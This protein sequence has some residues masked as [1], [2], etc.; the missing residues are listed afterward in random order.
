MYS[1][2]RE[3]STVVQNLKHFLHIHGHSVTADLSAAYAAPSALLHAVS[4][5]VDK[6]IGRA[7]PA[8]L[9]T[10]A[11][12]PTGREMARILKEAVFAEFYLL[13]DD[14]KRTPEALAFA[15]CIDVLVSTGYVVIP[16]QVQPE[17]RNSIHS[18][19]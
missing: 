5:V 16:S 14:V 12:D 17:N 9:E 19:D 10:M 3:R 2:P 15:D 4:V 18:W 8:V 1:T 13:S 11:A 6:F 7:E